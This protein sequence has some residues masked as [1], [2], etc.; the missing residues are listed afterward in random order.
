M[1]MRNKIGE[2]TPIEAWLITKAIEILCTVVFEDESTTQLDVDSNSMRGA[3]RE[4]T[5]WLIGR[6]YRPLGRWV[7]EATDEEGDAIETTRRFQLNP[8]D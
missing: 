4:I 1:G 2:S 5:G 7:T 3:Q 6:G 8:K